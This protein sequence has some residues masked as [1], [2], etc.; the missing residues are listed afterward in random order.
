MTDIWS[1]EKRSAVMAKIRGITAP[2][3]RLRA[4]LASRGIRGFKVG[5]RIGRITPDLIFP[6]EKIA[7]FVDGCF[8]HGCPRCYVR[9][10]TR[11]QYWKSKI[12]INMR[13]DN[14]QRRALRRAGWRV[15]RIWECQFENDA[16]SQID[17]ILRLLNKLGQLS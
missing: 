11:V 2:E 1:P 6:R 12:T 3:R 13:R 4:T 7:V 9:P 8:W 16:S 15:I 10:K 14:R 5:T 17:R